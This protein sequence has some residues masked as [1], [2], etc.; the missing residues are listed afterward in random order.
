MN[1]RG[2][3]PAQV[4]LLA[5][6]CFALSLS[7]S[8]A[9]NK[10]AK[11]EAKLL[12]GR[13]NAWRTENS[14]GLVA[15]CFDAI[16]IDGAEIQNLN[17]GTTKGTLFKFTVD[18]T[19]NPKVIDAEIVARGNIGE[20]RLGIYRLSKDVLE[21][22]WGD[23]KKRRTKFTGRPA[24]GA[25][26]EYTIYHGEQFKPPAAVTKEMKR[27]EGKWLAKKGGNGGLFEEDRIQ[28][29]TPAGKGP[30]AKFLVDPSQDPKEIEVIYTS[31]SE[32]Y[33][34]RIGIYQ[35]VGDTLTLSLSDLDSNKRPTKLKGGDAPGAGKW[36]AVYKRQ[37]DE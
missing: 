20:K 5:A 3:W 18:P 25:G 19:K 16:L 35:L 32:I 37:K 30:R 33:K 4:G 29:L 21:I 13:W 11:E 31:G 27:F 15:D 7:R 2:Y 12:Q 1:R 6:V 23:A 36:F 8:A 17:G 24:V 28:F 10:D 26:S 9:D 22:C 14:N 34:R